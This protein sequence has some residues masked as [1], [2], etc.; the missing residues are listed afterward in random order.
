[1]AMIARETG[2]TFLR[3]IEQLTA[4]RAAAR[5]IVE[6]LRPR[7]SSIWDE[8][9]P[10]SW[11]TAGFVQELASAAS[12]VLES[13]PRESLS[14][15]QLALAIATG[16][17]TGT[18]PDP[19]QAQIEGTAWKEIGTA[20]RYLNEYDA[21]L[22]AYNAAS[23]SFA[24]ANSLAHD[25]AVVDFARAIALAD[26]QRYAEAL[27]LL[28][29]VEP[30]FR[31]FGDETR[32]VKV[33]LLRGNICLLQ[34]RL[35]EARATYE[36]ALEEVSLEDLHTRAMLYLNLGQTCTN[37]GDM[38]NGVLMLHH[39]RQLLLDLGMSV[40]VNRTEWNL[41]RALL[42]NGEYGR[43]IPIL[44]RVRVFY[45][46]KRIPE[47][48]GLA[49]LD[50]ADALIATG[51]ADRAR[52]IVVQVLAEFT[53]SNLNA[54]A[55]TALAYLR[56]VLHTTRQPQRAVR[57]VRQ[58]LDQLRQEPTRLFLPPSEE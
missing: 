8:E 58:Y 18:Y 28:A 32:V 36:K 10:S 42:L 17:P 47:D 34:G 41:A 56:D 9:I 6:A 57:H 1:M 16:I 29:G 21:A 4:E 22:R 35:K 12:D 14:L 55:L 44:N 39:A 7:L 43:A 46:A 20:H 26:V 52:E 40:E 45:L 54:H 53:N 25:A 38:N 30:L 2:E 23:R 24:S 48:A 37:L 13:D 33:S 27:D 50:V 49:G 51:Q 15:A 11:R 19:V 5:P 31:S 3:T